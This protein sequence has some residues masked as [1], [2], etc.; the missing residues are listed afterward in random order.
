MILR[1]RHPTAHG[2]HQLARA[3]LMKLAHKGDC[4]AAAPQSRAAT[5]ATLISWV[6]KGR[7]FQ[8]NPGRARPRKAH[9]CALTGGRCP[10]CHVE[11]Y[12]QSFNRGQR[13]RP[14]IT[15]PA[16]VGDP[17]NAPQPPVSR[18]HRTGNPAR[19]TLCTFPDCR[20]PPSPPPWGR[21][22]QVTQ[23]LC[24][25]RSRGCRRRRAAAAGSEAQLLQ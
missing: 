10:V 19:G 8:K 20:P 15:I 7:G 3:S 14:P 5:V 9:A 25:R 6:C 22:R 12:G 23:A 17:P 16:C 21:P 4:A 18:T 13:W 1:C 11:A 24:D 2:L